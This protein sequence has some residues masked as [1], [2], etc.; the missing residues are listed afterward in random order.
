MTFIQQLV[1]FQCLLHKRPEL[2]VHRHIAC[3][4]GW[5]LN[6]M[7]TVRTQPTLQGQTKLFP[8]SNAL[9]TSPVHLDNRAKIQIDRRAEKLLKM[10]RVSRLGQKRE[11]PAAIVVDQ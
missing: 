7:Q 6:H 11:D 5:Y 1:S 2:A 10:L 9:K 3:A 8:G 4:L